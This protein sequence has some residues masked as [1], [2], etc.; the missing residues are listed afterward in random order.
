MR[1]Y[2][3]FVPGIRPGRN[4]SEHIN[5]ILTR[6][7]FVGGVYLAIVCLLPEWMISGIHLQHLPVGSAAIG[8]TQHMWRFVLD[9][10]ERAI[11]FRRHV[12]ADRRRRGHGYGAAAG[13]AARHA[14]L[15]R[16][17]AEGP[18]PGSSQLMRSERRW[19]RMPLNRALIFLGPPGAG[20]GT[21]AK[22]IAQRY[23]VPHLSTGDM[24]RDAVT[25]GTRAGPSGQADHGARR[26]GAGRHR[27]GHGRRAAVAA[28]LRRAGS[29]SMGFR[30]RCRRPKQ[31]DEILKRRGF[32]K[33]VVVE[34]QRESETS[35]CA[36]WRAAGRA[37]WAAKLTM[38]SSAAESG[39]HLR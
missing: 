2:G 18:S 37:A 7:T 25:R 39:G 35:C 38:F 13:S 11:L 26:A 31:L 9:G 23:E 24:L 14:E 33:P 20:K 30:G 15:R 10:L 27:D 29:S 6:L 5:R 21:Q 22:R 17:R 32:W 8:L 34:F 16:L 3:G 19:L 36:A 4:T 1:K 12:A 28:G